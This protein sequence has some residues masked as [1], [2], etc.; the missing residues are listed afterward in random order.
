MKWTSDNQP[1]M[2]SIILEKATQNNNQKGS[3]FLEHFISDQMRL[4]VK[5]ITFNVFSMIL[6]IL[7]NISLML[8]RLSR[9]IIFS[10]SIS[11]ILLFIKLLLLDSIKYCFHKSKVK[12]IEWLQNLDPIIII[13]TDYTTKLTWTSNRYMYV[14]EDR[15]V[16]RGNMY[17]V[18][19]YVSHIIDPPLWI[20]NHSTDEGLS[21]VF[22][23]EN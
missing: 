2:N 9:V 4:E 17:H 20:W 10:S 23:S 1:S 16:F 5:T 12:M 19:I 11:R 22:H 6:F 13:F 3:P 14:L 18:N 8:Y 7:I 21:S 15:C